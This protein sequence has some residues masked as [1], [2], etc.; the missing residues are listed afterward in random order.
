M[1]PTTIVAVCWRWWWPFAVSKSDW[2]EWFIRPNNNNQ[3]IEF[4]GEQNMHHDGR[5]DVS[6]WDFRQNQGCYLL[7]R[8]INTCIRT[9]S[10]SCLS[11][12]STRKPSKL[13]FIIEWMDLG[14]FA[15]SSSRKWSSFGKELDDKRPPPERIPR[16]QTGLSPSADSTENW[17]AFLRAHRKNMANEK[18]QTN[19]KKLSFFSSHFHFEMV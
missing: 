1:V 18:K 14:L 8:Q 7:S 15:N 9:V 13:L 12:R 17:N 2:N 5:N 4:A 16:A 19:K 11:W 3:S 10:Y 6:K